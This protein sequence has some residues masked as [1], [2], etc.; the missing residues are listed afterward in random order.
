MIEQIKNK[1]KNLEQQKEQAI[2]N[3]NAICGAEQV[4][5]ELLAEAEKEEG[6]GE[7]DD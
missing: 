5:Q 4:L 1:L 7:G 3:V 2:A 6:E